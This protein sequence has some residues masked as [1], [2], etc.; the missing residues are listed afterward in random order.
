[1]TDE[2]PI[3]ESSTRQ[4]CSRE[5]ITIRHVSTVEAYNTWAEIYDSDGNV[6]QAIDDYELETLLPVFIEWVEDGHGHGDGDAGEE[7]AGKKTI[8][9]VDLGCGTGRNTLKLMQASRWRSGGSTV[10]VLAI[11]ASSGML[12][13]ARRKIHDDASRDRQPPPN[14]PETWTVKVDFLCHD[15]LDSTDPEKVPIHLPPIGENPDQRVERKF[16]GLISTLVLEH[17]PLS[18]FFQALSSL[19]RPG[20]VALVT[21]MHPD[22]GL[23]S[24]AGF[25]SQDEE[26]KDIKI[27]GR[28]WIHGIN[29]TIE[30]AGECGFE[31]VG[32]GV[33]EC[34]VSGDMVRDGVVGKRG[35]KW[36][37]V[38]VWYGFIV[39][40]SG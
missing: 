25:T 12:D 40:K 17:F 37:G 28:S 38:K 36:V 22:M 2:S 29:E 11:D 16:N 1:M 14:P 39:R 30:A 4:Q 33:R 23:Q 19:L 32:G 15:F 31:I 26:G 7:E 34:A 21:N 5:K 10:K 9:I 6:L 8:E 27:R 13:I 18:P 20:G 3:S 24:Q 35:E